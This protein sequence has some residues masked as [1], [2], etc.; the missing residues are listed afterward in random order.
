MRPFTHRE[1]DATLQSLWQVPCWGCLIEQDPGTDR[2]TIM[3]V[4]FIIQQLPI[5][6]YN[7]LQFKILIGSFLLRFQTGSFKDTASITQG[8]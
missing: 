8:K 6:A 5:F 3:M 7:G 1:T 2:Q 4:D